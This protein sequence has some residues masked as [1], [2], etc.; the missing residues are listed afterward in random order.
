MNVADVFIYLLLNIWKIK[1]YFHLPSNFVYIS[2]RNNSIDIDFFLSV[3]ELDNDNALR[4]RE[5][6]VLLIYNF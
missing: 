6:C 1:L 4:N 5:C 3:N 2:S